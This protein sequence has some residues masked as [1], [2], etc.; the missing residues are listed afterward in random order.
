MTSICRPI[1]EAALRRSASRGGRTQRVEIEQRN[2]PGSARQQ[3]VQQ[4][5]PLSSKFRAHG[6]DAGDVAARPVETDFRF[7]RLRAPARATFIW[8]KIFDLALMARWAHL[9]PS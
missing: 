9:N 2:K 3:V 4:P 6:G 7:R 8:N 5:E 1:A